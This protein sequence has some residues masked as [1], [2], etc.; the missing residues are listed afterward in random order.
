MPSSPSITIIISDLC[1]GGAQKVASTLA[2]RWAEKGIPISVITMKPTED[3]FFTLSPSV[4]RLV[5]GGV[6]VSSGLFAS[7]LMN[8]KRLYALRRA[9]QKTD[10]SHIISFVT[11]TN[12]LTIVA[13]MGLGKK[14]IISER[15]NPA[16]QSHGKMWDF[17]R[18]K[19]YRYAAVVTANSHQAVEA[20]KAYVPEHKVAY[21]P[22]PVDI[23]TLDE[24]IQRTKSV[25]HVGKLIA[26]KAHD[27][28]LKAWA[29]VLKEHPDWRL[30]LVGDGPL[31]HDMKKLSGELLINDSI[32][33]HGWSHQVHRYY[34]SS[35]IFVLPSRF[36]GT[37]NALL[38]AMSYGMPCIV[39]N[40][41]GGALDFVTHNQTGLII[42]ADDPQVLADAISLL[43]QD[44]S[45]RTRLG[46]AARQRMQ[47]CGINQVLSQW[48]SVIG[49]NPNSTE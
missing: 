46:V 19:L 9:I 23:P 32:H 33:W 21:V 2:N 45:L 16:A 43:I 39:S 49:L 24:S 3:D 30:D 42:P 11:S 44:E 31:I 5:I 34:Q 18:V 36:E 35:G 14:V 4:I 7:I 41:T 8:L 26:Q 1:S 37:P 27:V 20:L 47:S 17:L 12:I 13:A 15:N 29:I 48:E 28:L 6:D 22:N 25:F 40:Q 38:E 10:T